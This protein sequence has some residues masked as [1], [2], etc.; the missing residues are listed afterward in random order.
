MAEWYEGNDALA[1]PLTPEKA[2]D[3]IVARFLSDLPPERQKAVRDAIEEWASAR[4]TAVS[5]T[6]YE[7]SF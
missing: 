1:Y 3:L 6:V 2:A 7:S 5:A 4:E